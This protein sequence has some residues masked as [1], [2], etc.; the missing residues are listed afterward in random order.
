MA[1]IKLYRQPVSEGGGGHTKDPNLA[2]AE[3]YLFSNFMST[4]AIPYVGGIGMEIATPL[5]TAAKGVARMVKAGTGQSYGIPNGDGGTISLTEG[6]PPSFSEVAWGWRGVNPFSCPEGD[7]AV[8]AKD[9]RI[10]SLL[11]FCEQYGLE[12]VQCFSELGS[13][14]ILKRE[15]ID[16]ND[17]TGPQG[18]GSQD[19]I[20]ATQSLPYTIVFENKPTATA[21]AE[22]VVIS[23]QLAANLDWST[24][25]LGSF[26]FGGYVVDVPAGLRATAPASMPL[27]P[28]A[29]TST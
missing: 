24:F 16:P 25:Q 27:A 1:E 4:E 13:G 9:A 23:E 29:S 5:W 26:G 3:H 19:F 14:E 8:A 10:R 15:P 7:R 22:T 2:A 6:S 12:L 28:S 20:P 11:K 21:P 18:F 17:L